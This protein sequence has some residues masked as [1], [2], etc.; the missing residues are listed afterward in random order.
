[1]NYSK[2]IYWPMNIKRDNPWHF[3]Q[4]LKNQSTPVELQELTNLGYFNGTN[5]KPL[6]DYYK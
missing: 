6:K 2:V 3:K 1:M 5:K 4:L